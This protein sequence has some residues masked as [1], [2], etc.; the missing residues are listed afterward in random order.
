MGFLTFLKKE[1]VKKAAPAIRKAELPPMPGP[2]AKEEAHIKELGLPPLPEMEPLEDVGKPELKPLEEG[3]PPE[4]LPEIKSAAPAKPLPKIE[5]PEAKPVLSPGMDEA[6]EFPSLEEYMEKE[7]IEEEI[8]PLEEKPITFHR[9][10]EPLA[11]EKPVTRPIPGKPLF[12]T[13]GN[14][15]AVL[16]TIS[17][18]DGRLDES[19]NT[20]LTVLDIKVPLDVEYGRLEEL[21]QDIERKIAYVDKI[22]FETI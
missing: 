1:E 21:L 13:L 7:G 15:K 12:L 16:G 14:F 2:S 17:E 3:E 4:A 20:L 18:V 5:K 19:I 6:P 22:F 10:K 8:P 9:P 11:I